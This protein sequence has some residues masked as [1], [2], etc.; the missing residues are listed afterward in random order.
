MNGDG[1]RGLRMAYI[2][3]SIGGV[4]FFV[5][6][7]LL[8]AVWPGRVLEDET[9]R[10]SPQHPLGLTTSEL[11]GR[12][13]YGREGC[14][15]CHTQ[16]IRYLQSDMAR[17]GAPTLAWETRFDYPQLWGTRR[18][19][20]DLS[21]EAS[22]RSTDWQYA[23]LYSPRSVVPDSIMPAFATLFDSS[24][25][26]P[27]QEARDLVSYLETLGR[28]REIAGPEGD[29]HARNACNC[30]DEMSQMAFQSPV[31][32]AS[33]ARARRSGPHPQL[34]ANADAHRGEEIY[35]HNCQGCH[36]VHGQGDGPGAESLH[37]QPP[38]F[39]EEEFTLDQLSSTLW[40]GSVGTAMPAWRDLPVEDLA[41]VASVVRG[42][43]A[44][45]KE[46]AFPSSILDLGA[47]VYKDH[48]AQCHG[49]Q[50]A[51]DGSAISELDVLPTN[52]R[53][54]RP[55]VTEALRVLRNGME[56][57]QM[58]PWS[59]KLS[60]AELSAVAYYIRGFFQPDAV[61]Q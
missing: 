7:V 17:F 9:R 16:Q 5:L 59:A 23:H 6:S 3:A 56:G 30:P 37:P 12:E 47:N 19:G 48:C 11:R 55:S 20:P 44:P 13:I 36:G 24:P 15:Y 61:R 49:D 33:P 14:A 45:Q 38:N 43:H 52:F 2:V 40:N 18:I 8:L 58:A 26:R 53:E 39:A 27:R 60:E 25:D 28:A 21:R 51:G 22:T 35:V 1:H 54:E 32:N 31:L 34:A 57:T 41:A 4:G 10:M 42:F 46:P 50:G 29:A